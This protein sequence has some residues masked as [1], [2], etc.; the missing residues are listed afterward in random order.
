MKV[1]F[2]KSLNNSLREMDEQVCKL[3]EL[4]SLVTLFMTLS[5]YFLE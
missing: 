5:L 1:V 3:Q 4:Q 2:H